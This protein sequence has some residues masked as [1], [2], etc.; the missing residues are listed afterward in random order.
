MD[1]LEERQAR[2][3]AL[4]QQA[5]ETLA[6]VDESLAATAPEPETLLAIQQYAPPTTSRYK[7][8]HVERLAALG[9]SH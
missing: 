7:G 3:A 2:L 6:S 5:Y 4:K 9:V 8:V 1:D